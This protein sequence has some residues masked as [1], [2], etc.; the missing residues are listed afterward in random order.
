MNWSI[1]NVRLFFYQRGQDAEKQADSGQLEAR[2][3]SSKLIGLFDR[4]NCGDDA[5]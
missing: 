3:A 5:S 2:M 1:Q 4:Y